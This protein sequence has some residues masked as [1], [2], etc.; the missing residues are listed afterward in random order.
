ML[1][2]GTQTGSLINHLYSRSK[3]ITPEVGMG[4]TLCGWSD[5]HACTIVWVSKSGKKIGVQGD[6]AIRVD[7]LGMS[8]SQNYE[9]ERQPDSHISYF[10]LRKNGMWKQVGSSYGC[11][12]IGVRDEYYDYSF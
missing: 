2:L 5:R 4:A 3:D 7:N 12:K 1:K 6:K 8:D 10:T 11:L 9:Y